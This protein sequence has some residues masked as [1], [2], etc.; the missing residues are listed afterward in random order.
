MATPLPQPASEGSPGTRGTLDLLVGH[1]NQPDSDPPTNG[2]RDH[3]QIQHSY[4]HRHHPHLHDN[5]KK[6]RN[7]QGSHSEEA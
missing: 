1:E 5:H 4:H 6:K 7:S 3:Q 2:D